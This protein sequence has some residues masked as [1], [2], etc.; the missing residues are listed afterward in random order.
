MNALQWVTRGDLDSR[1]RGLIRHDRHKLVCRDAGDGK[2]ISRALPHYRVPWV[3]ERVL[4][5]QQRCGGLLSVA[6]I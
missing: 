5:L 6:T 1:L 4:N 3:I 2:M